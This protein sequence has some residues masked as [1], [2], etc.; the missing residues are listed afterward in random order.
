MGHGFRFRFMVCILWVVFC[1]GL[2]ASTVRVMAYNVLA[3]NGNDDAKEAALRTVI[4]AAA[5]DVIMV[6]ELVDQAGYDHFLT[7]VLNYSQDSTYVGAPFTSQTAD[8][9]IALYYR[10]ELLT[11]IS[12]AVVDI[13][14]SWG[15]RD[16]I[17]FVFLHNASG[18]EIRFYGIHLKA[19]SGSDNEATRA[20]EATLL[21]QYL[22]TLP[23]G[24]QFL[25]MG[26]FNFYHSGEAGFQV[27]VDSTDDN[28]GRL[29]DPVNRIGYWHN[30]SAFADV[31]TQSPR[32]SFGGMDDRFDFIFA[33]AAI[34]APTRCNYL[35]GT[36]QAFGNDGNHFNMGI[37]EGNNT[38]VPPE[39]ANALVDASDHIPVMMDLDF[40]DLVNSSYQVVVSEIMP[41]P[42]AVSDSYG[43]WIELY[44]NDT[45]AV[46][47]TGWTLADGGVDHHVIAPASGSLMLQPGGYLVCAR[48]GDPNSN[49]GVPVDY[50]LSSFLLSNSD[51]EIY[52]YDEQ[53]H[54]VDQVEYDGSFPYASGVA[55]YIDDFNA[56][57]NDPANW[58]AA[59]TPYGLGD[60]GTPGQA[61]DHPL[62][63]ADHQPTLP[64]RYGLE[65]VY[66]NPFNATATI[67]Y[68]LPV[69]DQVNLS[70][71]DVQGRT[72]AVLVE[73][74]Q[75]AGTHTLH[76]QAGSLP[77]GVYIIRFASGSGTGT[78]KALLLK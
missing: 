59:T 58:H 49:G 30:N 19:S 74:R 46:D 76:W 36:Y 11:F 64:V 28:D 43:E 33:S 13:T 2:S 4:N 61:W 12:T 72:V 26:D 70:V 32:A 5:P 42:A 27:L 10:P 16:A 7:D 66:P 56:D 62:A 51:D 63:V 31:H 60:L 38:A 39:V 75:T 78:T 44:N 71:T 1:Q 67:R 22:D 47:L 52:L 69:S 9:D 35:P 29:F 20:A 73:G 8:K 23:A 17:E 57:N 18:E 45:V 40:T 34:L 41:N 48:N 54:L 3:F 53:N 68:R 37:N 24:S 50:E 77:S 25:V 14:N 55:M 6:E 65:P 15:L 21:R